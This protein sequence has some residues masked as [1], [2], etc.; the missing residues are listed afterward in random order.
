MEPQIKADKCGWIIFYARRASG[1]GVDC[2][3]GLSQYRTQIK[4]SY[5]I[6][7]CLSDFICG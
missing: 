4:S 3:N 1:M 7:L 2:I 5:L 6:H